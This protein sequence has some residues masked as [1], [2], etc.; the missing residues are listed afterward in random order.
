MSKEGSIA[1]RER[2]NIRYKPATRGDEEVE[3]PLT[4]LVTG[5]FTGQRDPRPLAERRPRPVDKDAFDEVLA[6]HRIALS[7]CV[8]DVLSAG[9][10]PGERAVTLE[11]RSLADF[12]PEAIVSQVPQL[13]ELLELR[14]ALTALRGPLG[15]I[16]EFRRRIRELLASD[17]DRARLYRELGVVE[18]PAAIEEG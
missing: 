8:P 1:P 3:L 15:N 9:D 16:P 13:R 4:I 5:D 6:D 17:S 12:G 2:V 10:D 7:L 18:E 14:S 11:L